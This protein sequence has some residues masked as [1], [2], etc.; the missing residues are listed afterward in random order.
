MERAAYKQLEALRE[1]RRR[2]VIPFDGWSEADCV[3]AIDALTKQV[4]EDFPRR[5]VN[6]EMR[7]VFASANGEVGEERFF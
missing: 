2:I 7:I 3:A 5:A 6:R 4:N 1:E